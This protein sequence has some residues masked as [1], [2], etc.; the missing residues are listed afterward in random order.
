MS[1]IKTDACKTGMILSQMTT[2]NAEQVGTTLGVSLVDVEK[3]GDGSG[4][5]FMMITNDHLIFPSTEDK[6]RVDVRESVMPS[7]RTI[8]N[9]VV[10]VWVKSLN[11]W[12]WFPIAYLR[13]VPVKLYKKALTH[14]EEARLKKELEGVTDTDAFLQSKGIVAETAGETVKYSWVTKE[15][16]EFFKNYPL[17]RELA[18]STQS[19]LDLYR[20]LIGRGLQLVDTKYLHKQA[21]KTN[22]ETKEVVRAEGEYNIQPCFVFRELAKSELK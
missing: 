10:R 17:G 2:E 18:S 20:S 3:I 19:D 8:R 4:L 21:F 15:E 6:A 11:D 5:S 16:E 13:R 22:R 14:A 1:N 7:G 9:L 12:D